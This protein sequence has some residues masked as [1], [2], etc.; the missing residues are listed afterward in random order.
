MRDLELTWLHS[1]GKVLRG[2]GGVLSR[3]SEA[4]TKRDRNKQL[5]SKAAIGDEAAIRELVKAGADPGYKVRINVLIRAID[6]SFRDDAAGF[7]LDQ[8][9]GFVLLQRLVGSWLHALACHKLLRVVAVQDLEAWSARGPRPCAIRPGSAARRGR[10]TALARHLGSE[11]PCNPV[12][13]CRVCEA[14][15]MRHPKPRVSLPSPELSPCEGPRRAGR[16]T[17]RLISV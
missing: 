6:Y 9:G 16:A 14:R 15:V 11:L 3:I 5:C 1:V 2:G 4:Q 12:P 7:R 10:D 8:I 17:Q 13:P